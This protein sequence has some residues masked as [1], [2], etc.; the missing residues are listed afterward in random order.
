[1]RQ[2]LSSVIQKQ[3]GKQMIP[4]SKGAFFLLTDSGPVFHECKCT[5]LINN[6]SAPLSL[7]VIG[8]ASCILKG[9]ISPSEQTLFLSTLVIRGNE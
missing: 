9:L 5:L 7:A 2:V 6:S 4:L 8:T 3:Q 1:M